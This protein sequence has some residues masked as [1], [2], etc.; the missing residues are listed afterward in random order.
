MSAEAPIAVA[1]ISMAAVWRIC[2][3]FIM[4]GLSNLESFS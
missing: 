3:I 1:A 2:F 4:M